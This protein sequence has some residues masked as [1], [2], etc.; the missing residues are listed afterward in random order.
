MASGW[1]DLDGDIVSADRARVS[2]FDHGFTRG[3]SIFETLRVYS[4]IPFMWASHFERLA[5]SAHYLGFPRLERFE[6]ESRIERLIARGDLDD[7]VL[8]VQV[9]SGLADLFAPLDREMQPT[10]VL[11]LTPLPELAPVAERGAS[12][13][14]S[15]VRRVHRLALDPRA[16]TGS[17]LN[18]VLAAREAR[19][20][21]FDEAILL[22][23]E[24]QVTETAFANLFA[25]IEGCWYTPTLESGILH[26]ITR[27]V[28]LETCETHE[29]PVVE[30]DLG[31]DDL[32]LA[33][34]LFACSSVREC[35]PIISVG[36]APVGEG[37]VGPETLGLYEHYRERVARY[38][39]DVSRG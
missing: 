26:G 7:G 11:T 18:S 8:R 16:K 10:T 28:L 38:V 23:A 4:G 14:V 30:H 15:T 17:Y 25:W 35:V 29:I 27:S 33:E 21:G 36:D 6:L 24:Q 37:R 20:L 39:A 1:V 12:A 19:S 3:D 22:N 13:M 5:Q 32:D 2:V 9:T 31:L 34:E